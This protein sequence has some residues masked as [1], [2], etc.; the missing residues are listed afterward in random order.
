[1][2]GAFRPRFVF[3]TELL[4]KASAAHGGQTIAVTLPSPDVAYIKSVA[5]CAAELPL[6][7]FFRQ[8]SSEPNV[9]GSRPSEPSRIA[10]A[11]SGTAT[12]IP[13]LRR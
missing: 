4:A 5:I 9:T 7:G 12:S 10:A 13:M 2:S 3:Y 6:T 11:S 8:S 1:M